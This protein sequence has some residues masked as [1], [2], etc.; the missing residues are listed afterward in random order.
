MAMT[1]QWSRKPA[2][3]VQPGDRVRTSGN[4]LTVSRI[5]SPFMGVAGMIAF[6]EDTPERW[7]KRPV[8][9]DSEVGGSDSRLTTSGLRSVPSV[10]SRRPRSLPSGTLSCVSRC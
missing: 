5:E 7:I 8:Q 10:T 3:S 1:H 4:E 9:A 6:I 2:S